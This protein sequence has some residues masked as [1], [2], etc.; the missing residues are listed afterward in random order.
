MNTKLRI[1][2]RSSQQFFDRREAGKLLANELQD[3]RGKHTVVLGIPRGGVIIA[4]EVANALGAALD[5]VLA[6]K[7][8]T[9]GHEELAMGSVSENG[10]L[11]LNEDVVLDIGVTEAYIDREKARQLAEIKRRAELFRHVRPRV[12]LEG[13]TVIITDDGVATGATTQAAV[14]AARAEKPKHLILALPVGPE[15]TIIKLSKD[16]DEIICLQAPPMFIAVGQFYRHFEP[17]EDEE[18][19]KILRDTIKLRYHRTRDEQGYNA[20]DDTI[21]R[22]KPK[23]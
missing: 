4:Q 19:L 10:S 22:A 8:G 14:W 21:A 2:S 7:L 11:F 5:I 20:Y 23:L 6:H 13:K 17:V 9:P 15:D 3:Y 16:V 1:L 12:S 18:V